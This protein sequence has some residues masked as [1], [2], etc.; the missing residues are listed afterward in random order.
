M[1]IY[2]NCHNKV[3]TLKYINGHR[4]A[5]K[6]MIGN[7]A[8]KSR[9]LEAFGLLYGNCLTRVLG[10]GSESVVISPSSL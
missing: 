6:G 7:G 2:T 8:K 10:I 5:P 9:L 3:R 4:N 1:Q